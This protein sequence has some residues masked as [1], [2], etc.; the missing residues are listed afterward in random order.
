MPD[1]REHIEVSVVERLADV[2][3]AHWDACAGSD[4]PFLSYDFLSSLEDSGCVGPSTGWLPRAVLIR[5][6]G[7]ALLAC[8]PLYLKGNS[9]GEYVFDWGWAEAYER[10]GGQYYPKLVCAV[11]FTPVT[12]PRLMVR[13]DLSAPLTTV[14]KRQ[15]AETMAGA[16]NA[17]KLSSLHANFIPQDDIQAFRDADYLPRIGLQYHW[18][19]N[20]YGCYD[21]FLGQLTS[22]KRKALKKER[23]AAVHDSG[24]TIQHLSG[25]AI[26]A[27][28]W[29]ALYGFYQDT[30]ARKRG[31]AYLNRDFFALLGERMADRVILVMASLDGEIIAGALNLIGKDALYGRYWGC[32]TDIRYLHFEL[33]YHQAIDIAIERGLAR[34]EAGAQGEHK[35]ARGYLPVLTHSAHFIPDPNFRAGIKQFLDHE[36]RAINHERQIL[37]GESPYRQE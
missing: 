4:N 29:D 9:M 36:H 30:S 7:G 18:E 5:D 16:A 25:D 8:A 14:L 10:A 33:C 34:V 37:L 17:A 6:E 2:P 28:H 12:G 19:N 3:R 32:K 22:R 11:P 15:L 26:Q 21:D 24:V 35:I 13:P 23:R 27:H 20:G 31:Q 1:G